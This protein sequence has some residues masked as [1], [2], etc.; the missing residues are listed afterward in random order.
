M[1]GLSGGWGSSTSTFSAMLTA[2]SPTRSRSALIFMAEVM[3]RR[4]TAS[5]VWVARSFRQRLSM[6]IWRSLISLSV[7]MIRCASSSRRW[8]RACD[9][10]VHALLHEP[11]H[12]E[13]LVAERLQLGFEVVPFH[14]SDLLPV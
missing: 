10:A 9:R 4:S 6:S 11:P 2:W 14:S 5:G 7:A 3:S 8:T 12:G 13:E 1:S